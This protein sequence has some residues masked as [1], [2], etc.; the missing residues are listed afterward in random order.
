MR[1]LDISANVSLCTHGAALRRLVFQRRVVGPS[2]QALRDRR[3]QADLPPILGGL[4][5][6]LKRSRTDADRSAWR[7]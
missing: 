6:P 5:D 2:P 7:C 4:I 1:R 3:P